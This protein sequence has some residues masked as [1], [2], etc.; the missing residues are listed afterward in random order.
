[1]PA[2]GELTNEQNPIHAAFAQLAKR[3]GKSRLLGE[4]TPG[5][6]TA[7]C[8]GLASTKAPNHAS[9]GFAQPS[10]GPFRLGPALFGPAP[11]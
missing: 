10:D 7:A 1:M 2:A 5:V 11:P 6:V 8:A 9:S 3:D 4:N